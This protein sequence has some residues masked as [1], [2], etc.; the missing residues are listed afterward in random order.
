MYL[1]VTFMVLKKIGISKKPAEDDGFF[2]G[3]GQIPEVSGIV[4]VGFPLILPNRAMRTGYIAGI[5]ASAASSHPIYP[6]V[7]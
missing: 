4:S 3:N 6:L 5:A 1:N 2:D 7:N